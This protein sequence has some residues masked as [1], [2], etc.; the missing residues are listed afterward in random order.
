MSDYRR[1]RS[2]RRCRLA[3]SPTRTRVTLTW[4]P[5]NQFIVASVTLGL[6][7]GSACR[8]VPRDECERFVPAPSASTLDAK[9]ITNVEPRSFLGVALD[10][11]TKNRLVGV[12]FYF[13]EL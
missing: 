11:V 4:R 5:M 8:S 13:E 6:V 9:F 7:L 3:G 1:C 12:S 10:S 2:S